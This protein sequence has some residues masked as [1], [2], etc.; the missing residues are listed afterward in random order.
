MCMGMPGNVVEPV[1]I[2]RQTVLVDVR[3]QRQQVSAA[4]LV[5]DEVELPQV[6]D[7]VLVHM[8]FAMSRMDASEARSVLGSVDALGDMY[9]DQ[10]ASSAETESQRSATPSAE[11]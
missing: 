1:D 9:D 2:E 6:G 8:G 11:V 4:M 10:L 7:W 5:G 3:G